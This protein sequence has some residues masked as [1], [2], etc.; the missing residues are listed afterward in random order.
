MIRYVL[1]AAALK[2]FSCSSPTRKLYR[3]LGNTLGT[4]Q[5]SVHRM[6]SY[7]PQR[8]TQTLRLA[9]EYG[10][11]KD[12]YRILE[13]GT[14]WL[15]WEAIT[16]RLFFNITGVVCD[17]WDN[18]QMA[19]LKNYLSQLDALL[20]E[21][22]ADHDRVTNARDLLAK[23]LKVDTYDELYQLLGFEYV[24][25]PEGVLSPFADESFDLVISRGVME[26]IRSKDADEFVRGV[27]RVVKPGG[28]SVH[29]IN[30]LDHLYQY[31]Q[32]VSPKQYLQYSDRVWRTFFE[33]DVQYINKLQ[34]SDW[35]AL[36]KAAGL[37]LVEARV[38]NADLTGLQVTKAYRDRYDAEDLRCGGLELVHR[39]PV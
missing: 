16:S 12:N 8:V 26:H 30:L 33:N 35:L 31:D 20:A 24:I 10:L 27:A 11:L 37:D 25:D 23:I 21:H 29:S 28:Y 1:A 13:L 32:A 2:V 22:M 36:F 5:R 39:K 18:R 38:D 15:H 34:R 3:A 14:G 4:R 6:P 9:K 17:V 7:Y 19:G